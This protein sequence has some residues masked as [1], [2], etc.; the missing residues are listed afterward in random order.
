MTPTDLSML[1]QEAAYY[2]QQ[3]AARRRENRHDHAGR[4][5]REAAVIEKRIAEGEAAAVD[6]REAQAS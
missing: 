3:E 4:W 6:E 5:A 2:R 1:R